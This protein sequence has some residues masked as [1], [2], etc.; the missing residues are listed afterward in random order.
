ML[1]NCGGK[2]KWLGYP[3]AVSHVHQWT[4]LRRKH[5]HTNNAPKAAPVAPVFLLPEISEMY[6]LFWPKEIP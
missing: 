4:Q 3:G 5:S 2:L 6:K 1:I